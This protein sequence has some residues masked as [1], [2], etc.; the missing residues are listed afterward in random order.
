MTD[1]DR[2]ADG[3]YLLVTTFRKDGRAV[4]TPVWVVRDGERLLVWTV[5]DSGKVKRIRNNPRV[6]VAECDFKGNPTGEAV[7]AT[8]R[9][10]DAEGAER[11]RKLIRRKYGI[12][13]TLVVLGSRLRRGA[14]GTV[15]IEITV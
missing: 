1:L 2:L 4:P 6:E 15:G 14:H 13:G 3:K 11:A 12:S 9:L 8:A 7:P 5:A 10:L